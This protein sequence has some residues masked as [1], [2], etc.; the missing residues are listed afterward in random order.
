[1]GTTRVAPHIWRTE[2]KPVRCEDVAR[3]TA[4]ERLALSNPTAVVSNAP[5][6]SS[7]NA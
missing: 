7:A 5:K 2:I 4:Q 3:S 6:R 1:M